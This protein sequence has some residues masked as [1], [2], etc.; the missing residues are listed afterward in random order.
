MFVEGIFRS[1]PAIALGPHGAEVEARP[2]HDLPG[3]SGSRDGGE[4]SGGRADPH[5]RAR[6]AEGQDRQARTRPQL[7]HI[8][9]RHHVDG[10]AAAPDRRPA[11]RLEVGH[12]RCGPFEDHRT[13]AVLRDP[14]SPAP[15]RALREERAPRGEV[16]FVPGCAGAG[17]RLVEAN[18]V[19][20][21]RGPAFRARER[22]EG[23]DRAIERRRD[24]LEQARAKG[25]PEGI[26]V[27]VPGRGHRIGRV[28]GEARGTTLAGPLAHLHELAAFEAQGRL[29]VSVLRAG[30]PRKLAPE[31]A[32][33]PQG[34]QIQIEGH[35]AGHHGG[36]S[37]AGQRLIEGEVQRSL[38]RGQ[39]EPAAVA[40]PR[41][42]R[43]AVTR[44]A[45]PRAARH[46]RVG[47]IGVRLGG[48]S[49]Q[50]DGQGGEGCLEDQHGLERAR[51][52]QRQAEGARLRG[53]DL[54]PGP[55]QVAR[56]ERP[57]RLELA[58]H[59]GPAPRGHQGVAVFGLAEE[60]A[61]V[62][63]GQR[64]IECRDIGNHHADGRG[65]KRE[66]RLRGGGDVRKR[67]EEG[68]GE[69][70]QPAAEATHSRRGLRFTVGGSL[71][72]LHRTPPAASAAAT[73]GQSRSRGRYGTGRP[74]SRR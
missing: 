62:G 17:G 32:V 54:L 12:R 68:S 3:R 10:S 46:E 71:R 34:G 63:A 25:R 55:R 64:R 9:D 35:E 56:E 66:A 51:R 23:R 1:R 21:L 43:T 57:L 47:D 50:R 31:I 8:A 44:S 58:P 45:I 41:E 22:P 18:Q 6:P 48:P 7:A 49:R 26:A 52:E 28:E 65:R 4:R 15:G 13:L 60:R 73:T 33:R 36:R 67:E 20:V 5:E 24:R 74:A 38:A 2:A 27:P 11:G 29:H 59:R 14:V 70:E 69:N 30:R 72:G 39:E 42:T 61:A 53:E 40:R 16:A 37:A 19:A